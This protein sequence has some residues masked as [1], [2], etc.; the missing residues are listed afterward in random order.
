MARQPRRTGLQG[1]QCAP[2]P[3]PCSTPRGSAGRLGP[4]RRGAAEMAG[5]AYR[6]ANMH[7]PAAATTSP[8]RVGAARRPARVGR[9][10]SRLSTHTRRQGA[11]A[12]EARR[13]GAPEAVATARLNAGNVARRID[14]KVI[15]AATFAAR[16]VCVSRRRRCACAW[17]WRTAEARRGSLRWTS[18]DVRLRWRVMSAVPRCSR[19]TTPPASAAARV[20]GGLVARQQRLTRSRGSRPLAA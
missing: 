2:R 9:C 20:S 16:R 5:H 4:P 14:A 1:M 12:A 18:G 13:G 15:T 19:M 17:T 8:E 11:V 10:G 6:E 7:V 3:S